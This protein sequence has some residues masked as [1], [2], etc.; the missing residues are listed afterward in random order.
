MMSL[1][2]EIIG[3]VQDDLDWDQYIAMRLREERDLYEQ[4]LAADTMSEAEVET[5]VEVETK[6]EVK[7]QDEIIDTQTLQSQ[8]QPQPQID[9]QRML[10]LQ[11]QLNTQKQMAQ[12]AQPIR[13]SKEWIRMNTI[14]SQGF[15]MRMIITPNPTIKS[16]LD[17]IYIFESEIPK[18]IEAFICANSKQ[19]T[20]NICIFPKQ[21]LIPYKLV[22][23]QS[24]YQREQVGENKLIGTSVNLILPI[25]I[26][27]FPVNE[28]KFKE[29]E[30]KEFATKESVLFGY[31]HYLTIDRNLREKRLGIN[32]IRKA[33][34]YGHPKGIWFGYYI[35]AVQKTSLA[36]P[37]T[38]WYK[39]INPGPAKKAGC[40]VYETKQDGDRSKVRDKFFY[41]NILPKG[42]SYRK[43][44][45]TDLSKY[46]D[47]VKGTK[48]VYYPSQVHW[49]QYLKLY[50][51]Y[52]VEKEN[53]IISIFSLFESQIYISINKIKL[54]LCHL[55]LA[56]G[57]P[58]ITL[59]FASY[60]ANE[61]KADLLQGY[62]IGSL[63]RDNLEKCLL[64]NNVYLELY[65]HAARYQLSDFCIPLV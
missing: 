12:M 45:A 16:D 38:P 9:H 2:A 36:H 34:N 28:V 63:K 62:M 58:D 35:T 13:E 53:D 56:A 50:D 55:V 25:K 59:Q 61:M 30:Y 43:A 8:T 5:K 29:F 4:E 44:K 10:D 48:I 47:L 22:Y 46:L 33:L 21:Y 19:D 14:M 52:V 17:L 65:N 15:Q 60:I 7:P 11:K 57:D 27:N 1:E 41:T 39:V 6:A 26:Q 40:T 49:N 37:I 32:S 54:N 3:S 51:T 18:N 23:L 42:Y 31:M 20:G 24:L 64:M